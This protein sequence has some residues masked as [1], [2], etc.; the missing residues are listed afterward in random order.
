MSSHCVMSVFFSLLH[1]KLV[2]R[3]RDRDCG[4]QAAVECTN[5]FLPPFGRRA[6]HDKKILTMRM[7]WKA[8]RQLVAVLTTRRIQQATE[9]TRRLIALLQLFLFLLR[10]LH[11]FHDPLVSSILKSRLARSPQMP[12]VSP[13]E[14][15]TF[16]CRNSRRGNVHRHNN[17]GLKLISWQLS[18]SY[19]PNLHVK[20]S[21]DVLIGTMCGVTSS[22]HLP[23]TEISLIRFFPRSLW[24]RKV[25]IIF[26]NTLQLRDQKARRC[27]TFRYKPVRKLMSEVSILLSQWNAAVTQKRKLCADGW[28]GIWPTIPRESSSPSWEMGKW[29]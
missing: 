10:R 16:R 15:T 2:L 8:C 12:T 14:G 4:I 20:F 13:K 18:W 21:S 7:L 27:F 29:R 24:T 1:I 22:V 3:Q 19:M 5:Q 26:F 25:L 9:Q 17:V 28:S 11:S 23:F 6:K